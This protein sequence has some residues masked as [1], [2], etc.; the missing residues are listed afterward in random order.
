[1]SHKW[2]GKIDRQKPYSVTCKRCGVVVERVIEDGQF[3]NYHTVIGDERQRGLAPQ[4]P[5]TKKT[6]RNGV[7]L[8]DTSLKLFI[9]LAEDARNWHSVIPTD[10]NVKITKKLRGNLTN[11]KRAGLIT[12]KRENGSSWLLFT[13]KGEEYADEL[14]IDVEALA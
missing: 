11:L 14:G 13:P 3:K 8:T 12:V 9:E 10:G 2:S 6:Q 1:M 5:A 7:R 4:C